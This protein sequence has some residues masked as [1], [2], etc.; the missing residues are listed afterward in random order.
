[1]APQTEAR[2][3]ASSGERANC[4]GDELHH[5]VVGGGILGSHPPHPVTGMSPRA[6]STVSV[7][8]LPDRE[9]HRPIPFPK[10]EFPKFDGTNPRLWRDRCVMYFEVYAVADSLKTRFAAL[11]FEGAAATWLQTIER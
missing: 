9:S 2:P 6:T 4:H 8:T 5:R 7:D 3:S 1:M 10:L 11:N